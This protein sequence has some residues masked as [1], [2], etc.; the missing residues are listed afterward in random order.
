MDVSIA[1]ESG[2]ASGRYFSLPNDVSRIGSS[3]TADVVVPELP[4]HGLTVMRDGG[5]FTVINRACDTV[6]LGGRQLPPGTP[7]AWRVGQRI[8]IGADLDLRLTRGQVPELLEAFD[9]PTNVA[10]EVT[11]ASAPSNKRV[12]SLVIAI[13]VGL[14]I[15][16]ASTNRHQGQEGVSQ[17]FSRIL[18]DAEKRIEGDA[19]MKEAIFLLTRARWEEHWNDFEAAG[20]FYLQVRKTLDRNRQESSGVEDLEANIRN[21]VDA[22]LDSI[23][24]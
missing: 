2:A 3:K 21:F 20:Q 17:R 14:V 5:S 23:G 22:R 18:Y 15:N 10:E 16:F 4:R 24:I 9:D 19:R 7:R 12:G 6:S 1:I 13:I 8:R 11:V